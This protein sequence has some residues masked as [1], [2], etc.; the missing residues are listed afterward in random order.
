ML[1]WLA[2][3]AGNGKLYTLKHEEP[4]AWMGL[5]DYKLKGRIVPILFQEV[6]LGAIASAKVSAGKGQPWRWLCFRSLIGCDL[7]GVALNVLQQFWVVLTLFSGTAV[8]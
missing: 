7:G 4:G 6:F 1:T 2:S 3:L 5:A 8:L